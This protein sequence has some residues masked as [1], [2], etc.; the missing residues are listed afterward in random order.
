[1]ADLGNAKSERSVLDAKATARAAV[2][3]PATAGDQTL[4]RAQ[5]LSG[6]GSLSGT[7]V[8]RLAGKL[9]KLT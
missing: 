6:S 4:V 3:F 1:M 8:A 5:R 2:F 9:S 7:V